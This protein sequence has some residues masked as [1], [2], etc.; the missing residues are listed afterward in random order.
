MLKM[1]I[2]KLDPPRL[3]A[4]GN[5]VRISIKHCANIELVDNEQV[6]FVTPTETEYDVVRKSWGYYATPSLNGRLREYGL[7][8]ALVKNSQGKF[9]VCLVETGR[10]P[11][12]EEYL[13]YQQMIIISWLS[14]DK[15]LN[16]I[17]ECIKE[18]V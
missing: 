4:V 12:F 2:T 14:T 10:E 15:E 5:Q 17:E 9:F 3:F 16:V 13:Q 11:D 7:H 8:A 6:T 18:F 1:K